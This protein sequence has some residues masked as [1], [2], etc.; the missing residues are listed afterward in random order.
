[1]EIYLNINISPSQWFFIVIRVTG[2]FWS[3]KVSELGKLIFLLGFVWFLEEQ[4]D[5]QFSISFIIWFLI[6]ANDAK[7]VG[8]LSFIIIHIFWLYHF[9]YYGWNSSLYFCNC[10]R[11]MVYFCSYCWNTSDNKTSKEM[12]KSTHDF[13]E[14][15]NKRYF[16]ISYQQFGIY[17]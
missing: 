8:E 16:H 1:M 13:T 15:V 2:D 14:L 5:F 7:N 4:N 9:H 17:V 10:V 12:E 3:V 6:L 11:S